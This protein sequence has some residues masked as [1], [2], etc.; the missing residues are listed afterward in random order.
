MVLKLDRRYP[1]VWRSPESLQVGVDRSLLVI[2]EVTDAQQQLFAAL[3]AGI[4]RSGLDMIARTVEA[5]P[6]T[7]DRLLAQLSGALESEPGPLPTATVEGTGP[8]AARLRLLLDGDNAGF[9]V[10]IAHHVIDP[11]LHGRWLRRDVPHLP[12][13]FGDAVVRIGPIVEPGTGPCL[14]CLAL[15]RTDADPAW[16]AIASQLWGRPSM[17]ESALV[18]TETAG[19]VARLVQ[20]RQQ[21]G[22]PGPATSIELDS[23]SGERTY[24]EWARHPD[25]QCAEITAAQP[26]ISMASARPNDPIPFLPRTG[27][28]ADV[29]A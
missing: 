20:A 11:E 7:V 27:V 18:A 21:R 16:P 17:L 22:T 23:T 9:V 25:C 8:T 12:V 4:S 2:D 3:V 24:R 26:E 5:E 13:V 29:R 28:T 6:G 10:I 15:H 19:I 1:L 14:Y